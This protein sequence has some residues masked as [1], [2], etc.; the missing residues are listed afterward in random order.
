MY[1]TIFE[2]D[3]SDNLEKDTDSYNFWK[4]YLPEDRILNG[5]KSDNFWEMGEIGPCGPC[6]EIHYDNR[7]DIERKKID[8][9]IS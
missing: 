5:N 6:S 8:G 2:G 3:S 7:D 9:A 1:V 4:N